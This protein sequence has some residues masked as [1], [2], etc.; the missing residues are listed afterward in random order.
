MTTGSNLQRERLDHL[1]LRVTVTAIARHMGVSRQTVHT[2][3]GREFVD[4]ATTAQY[5]A[6]LA[7][8]AREVATG[9]VA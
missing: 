4:E 6:A 1:P 7:E 3:E 5:R 2:L 8:A 9:K